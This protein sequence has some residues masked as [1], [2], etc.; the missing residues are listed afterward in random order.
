MFNVMNL[1]EDR[2]YEF[3]IVAVNDAGEGKPATTLRNVL[4]KDPKG[5]LKCLRGGGI[6]LFH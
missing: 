6:A 3:R 4:V 5:E 1:I 2:E